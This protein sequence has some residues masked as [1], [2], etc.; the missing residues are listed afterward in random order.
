MSIAAINWALNS[1]TG[2]TS[3]EKAILFAL[4][5]RADETHR[6]FPSY[7]DLCNRSCATRNTV[8]KA[9]N[10]FEELKLV[11]REKRFGKST[12]YRLNVTSSTEMHTTADS[13][14]TKKRTTV[15]F[16]DFWRAYPRKANKKTAQQAFNA[17][18]VTDKKAAMRGLSFYEFG[19]EE[20]YIPHASTWLR[21]RRWEDE[22]TTTTEAVLEI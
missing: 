2:I 22:A 19:T 1:V 21:Q 15:Q 14:S 8:S 5:D 11:E 17:L 6:C 7:D 16:D 9:L 10:R 20:R 3:S 4:G 18:S 13:S 12:V